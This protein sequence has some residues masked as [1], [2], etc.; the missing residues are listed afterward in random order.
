MRRNWQLRDWLDFRFD[1][2]RIAA[3]VIEAQVRTIAGAALV[4]KGALI[5]T[6]ERRYARYRIAAAP[7]Y[8]AIA[9]ATAP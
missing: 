6:G 1:A 8:P 2:D 3:F 4:E 5:R 9:L 7:P